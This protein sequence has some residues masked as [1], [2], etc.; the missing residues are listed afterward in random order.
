M[1]HQLLQ[2]AA[3]LLPGILALCILCTAC[4]KREKET[5]PESKAATMRL[6]KTEGT[7][8][9]DDDE[10]KSVPPVE[11]LKL[12]SGYNMGTQKASYAWINL[13]DVKLTK[14][15]EKSEIE[16][17]KADKKLEILVNRGNLYFNI[18]E[19]LTEDENMEINTST[20][21]VGIRGTC[22]WI[23]AENERHGQVYLLE[24]KVNAKGRSAD[25]DTDVDAGRMADVTVDEN[26]GVNISV[27]E[28]SVSDIPEFVMEELKG[29]E[30]LAARILAAC[31]M[32]VL[33]P[34]VEA[35][36]AHK[37]YETVV[38]EYQELVSRGINGTEDEEEYERVNW[39]EYP[40]VTE[41]IMFWGGPDYYGYYDIDGNGIDELILGNYSGHNEN[42]EDSYYSVGIYAFNG[43]EAV[44][45]G[46]TLTRF[47]ADGTIVDMTN[48]GSVEN[49]Y[50]IG[51]DGFTREKQPY[52]D[53]L[54]NE[55]QPEESGWFTSHGGYVYNEI[56]W[57]SFTA[58]ED[59]QIDE[60]VDFTA[61]Q[62]SYSSNDA[63]VELQIR[64]NSNGGYTMST[65]RP[66]DSSHSDTYDL[67]AKNGKFQLVFWETGETVFTL[68]PQNGE[69]V[70]ESTG[71]VPSLDYL[72]GRYHIK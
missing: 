44:N 29:D 47:L 3:A 7:V 28:F 54:V 45:I 65:P 51:F 48:G 50:R 2:R 71:A 64:Q 60:N 15:D 34:P 58:T 12:Y 4:S 36:E 32:D 11:K 22:G 10:G 42:R 13:D 46:E 6:M 40:H 67:E 63:G 38:A 14:M 39:D 70:A 19:P 26:G 72:S 33:N 24:G 37:A 59:S 68:T 53:E 23:A 52:P 41:D 57:N 66:G 25:V 31:G 16:I 18:T 8:D 43:S 55:W 62:G 56:E 49:V 21:V 61:Y 9:I 27:S 20:M 30:E 69:L 35:E 1:K 5:E 17:Q